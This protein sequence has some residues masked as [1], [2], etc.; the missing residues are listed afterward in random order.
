MKLKRPTLLLHRKKCL[1]N[2]RFMAEKAHHA[3]VEFRPHFKTHQSAEIGNWFRAFGVSKIAV[4]SVTMAEY[5]A[6]NGWQ[7]ITI[8]FPLNFAEIDEINVLAQKTRLGLL[9]ENIQGVTFLAEN[10]LHDV[11]VFIKI[12]AGYHRTGID[13]GDHKTVLSLAHL[14]NNSQ[15]LS[16]KGLI[17]HNGNTYHQ[18]TRQAVLDIHDNSLKKLM[19]LKQHL[20]EN[21]FPLVVSVGDTPALSLTDNFAGIDEIRPGNFVFYDLMQQAIGVCQ[22]KDIAVAL[23]CPVIAV[24]PDRLEVVIYGGAIHLSKDYI[25]DE[26]GKQ[27]F[28]KIVWLTEDG[29]SEPVAETFVKSLSQEHGII[30]T[31]KNN[32]EEFQP[33]KF[34]GILPVHSCLTTNLTASLLTTDGE[35]IETIRKF[36]SR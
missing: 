5:F 26:N 34:I 6:G 13:V 1:S 14:I 28:G 7:D 3:G 4:S 18:R 27:V 20:T 24:H 17:V 8:A 2:I 22:Y 31:S 11:D 30:K 9:V 33:G 32:F 36:E 15:H 16:F 12:D 25:K 35:R 29:W 23:A 10:L 19:Q 21:G